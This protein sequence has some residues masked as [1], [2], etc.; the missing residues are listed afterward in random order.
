LDA[1]GFYWTSSETT[2]GRAWFYNFGRGGQSLNRQREGDKQ[3]A[4]SVRCVRD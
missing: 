4:I 2:P 3:M 1:H